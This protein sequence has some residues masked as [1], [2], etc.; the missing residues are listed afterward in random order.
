MR[1]RVPEILKGNILK[2]VIVE[3]PAKAQTISRFLGK[4]YKVMASYGHIRDLP[5]SADEIPA[6]YRDKPWARIAVD[7]EG[8][9]TPIYVVTK[10]S[11]PRIAE[12]KKALQEAD[13]VVLATDEDREGESISWHL[14]ETLKPKVPVSRIAF[15]E[16]T[17]SAIEEALANPR[18]VDDN[19]VRAQESRRVLD[20]LFGYTL[21]PVLWKKVRP[22]LSAGRVQSVAVRLVVEREEE[23][24]AFRNAS[25]W[26]VEAAMQAEGI[27]FEASLISW[28]GKRPASGKDFDA[29]TGALKDE[30]KTAG[31]V[32]HLQGDAAA[33]VSEALRACP[34]WTVAR[35]EQKEARLK[36][37]PPF[38]TS[39]LQQA[40][41]SVL[42]MSPRETMRIAQRLYEGVNLGGGEREGLITYMRTDSLTLSDKALAEAGEVIRKEF[43]D[44]YYEGPKR[45]STK[46]KNAQ[47]AHEAIR[48]THL[49]RMP[50]QVRPYLEKADFD[51]YCLVWN[52]TLA[53]Q[54]KG[55][56][57]LKTAVDFEAPVGNPH[58]VLRANGSV[59][60]FP[61]HLRVADSNQ[62]DT[63]LPNLSEGQTV[64][65]GDRGRD[66]LA[67]DMPDRPLQWTEITPN[68]HR[69]QPPA[70]YTE[71]S[72]VQRLEEEGIGRPSTYAPTISTIQQRG[73]VERQ[74]KVL[75]P[76]FLAVAVIMLLRRHFKEYVDL[77]FTARMENLLDDI[78]NGQQDSLAFLQ[79]FYRGGGDFGQGLEAQIATEMPTI[80]FPAI[81]IG[82]D[83]KNGEPLVV[84]LGRN[85]PF[86]QRGEGGPE[87]TATIPP[88]VLF[89][90][91]TPEL[92]CKLLHDKVRSNEALGKHPETGQSIY[93]LLGP[94]GPYV[95]LGEA[96]EK[97]KAKPKRASLPKGMAMEDVDLELALR[98]LSLP[99]TLGKHPDSGDE[100][101]AGMGRFGPYVKCGDDFRSLEADDDVYTVELPRALELLA[102][103]KR[104]RRTRTVLET[105]G[106]HP[107]SGKTVELCDGRYGPFVTDGE[108][109][110]SLP[111]EADPKT[112]TLERAVQML[113]EAATQKKAAPRKRAAA[114]AKPKAKATAKP[115]AKAKA[116]P[117]AK[118]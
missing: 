30:A 38:M 51:L 14:L 79:G 74:G 83:P 106:E 69:T 99:R 27:P 18:T 45:Y 10:E 111:K 68:E 24:R 46:S 44:D 87:N 9:F 82:E 116:K 104:S 19:L 59:V 36:P 80:E 66:G 117:K 102:Q 109:N 62:T 16:I 55:A 12:L 105:L 107:E 72:L 33:A 93:L 103:P 43:G 95:Q 71:A 20:R 98:L 41:S 97:S 17:Q 108:V 118:K 34:S 5:S 86:I 91:L 31:Q 40:A 77:G 4:E 6:A 29:S 90:D 92:A 115:K 65:P 96:S 26:S 113:A 1:F 56:L 21:S 94:F 48:P 13:E 73:Y 63:R 89:E 112:V 81:A 28:N 76:T 22:R 101:S 35:V 23:R 42:G 61:G 78:S 49:S 2:L 85:A 8:G 110:A 54:M 32:V 15:H 3:S 75:I 67:E 11:R 39:T 7:I 52:R 50:E 47:E 60:A 114:K 57:L 37:A 53:S 88:D 58:A 64:L 84:R 25:Y 100:I 70:R